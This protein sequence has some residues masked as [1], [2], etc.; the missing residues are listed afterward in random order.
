[1]DIKAIIFDFDDTLGDREKYSY[2]TFCEVLDRVC[3]DLDPWDREMVLQHM[4]VLDQHG[5]VNRSYVRNGILEKFGIDLG[6]N[7]HE[8]WLGNQW[9]NSV[10]FEDAFSVL[11]TLKQRGYKIG[12]L[13]NGEA[14]G[15]R[16]KLR[17][18]GLEELVDAAIASGE[19]DCAKPDARIFEKIAGMLGLSTGECAYVGDMFRND[20]YGAHKAGMVPVWFWPHGYRDVSV[21]VL[22]IHA[23]SDLL[24]L[25]EVRPEAVNRKRVLKKSVI[26]DEIS[27]DLETAFRIAREK[28]YETVELHN[29]FGKSIEELSDE[30]VGE[31]K[32][33]LQKY[34]LRV[35]DIASTV[36]FLCPLCE[37]DEVSLF[38]D[39][40]HAVTGNM[41]EHLQYLER[42]CRIADALGCRY[43]RVFPFRFPDNR[44]PPY[45]TEEDMERIVAAMRM[46]SDIA[47]KY[48]VTLVVE[49]CPYSHLPKAEMTLELVQRIHR[50]NVKMLYD[51]ANSYRA[52]KENV[53]EEYLGKDI[54]EEVKDILPEV[55]HIHVKDY[56][57]DPEVQPRPFVHVTAGDGDLP[58]E[59]LFRC[60]IDGRYHGVFSLEPEADEEGTLK[61]M[62]WLSAVSEAL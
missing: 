20:I 40:F 16:A 28:G 57:Y 26:A 42:A 21:N 8:Y 36:F 6:E 33:L 22:R 52:V 47:W 58:Y 56:H 2:R 14:Y 32:R 61:S 38:N 45:G 29:V 3:P 12:I 18:N 39:S 46:A 55:R 43:V 41:E 35:S 25:F 31:V 27:E 37:G 48:P 13:T 15:Q 44:K 19:T 1:M 5:E 23:L 53:P 7:L 24:N 34:Q 9:R 54:M 51:P 62:D 30:E 17:K 49:N 50:S 4:M 59:E 60:F 10:L 11:E